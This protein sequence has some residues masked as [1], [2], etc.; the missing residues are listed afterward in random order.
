[1]LRAA[2]TVGVVL[3]LLAASPFALR[4][5]QHQLVYHPTRSPLP[6]A[7]QV[8][9]GA[10]DLELTTDDG[11]RLVSWFVPPSP[12]AS[13]RDEAV[14]LAHGNGGNLAG[15]A[16]L[17]AELADRGFA[18]L[19]VGYRGYA[20]NPGTPAQDGLVLDALAG[21][22]ALESRGFPAARTIYLG[23]SIGTGVVVGL[24]AQ[25]PPA[26]LVLRSP[27]TSLA[28]VAGS[29]VPLPGPVLRFIL[30]RN[31]YPLAEQVAASDVPVTVLSGTADEVVPHAQSQAVAQ[32][33]TH[34]VEHVVL[35]G[36]RHND[37]VWLGPVVADAVERLADAVIRPRAGAGSP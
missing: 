27:F 1:M 7:E 36:A 32:A 25:V 8:L 6:A 31:E 22:R 20:G 5:M 14:L 21:Q 12:A 10:E 23:E 16:R 3:A 24:A 13:A 9:P 30:D 35:D 26:G 19:L 37:G 34:L 11:L 4:A 2:V 29:V 33:A 28:D 18:V 15:R 17:A